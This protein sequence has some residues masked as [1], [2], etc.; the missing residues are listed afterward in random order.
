VKILHILKKPNDQLA[1]DLIENQKQDPEIDVS[2]L[3]IHDA[4]YMKPDKMENLF[5]CRDDMEARC[6]DSNGTPVTYEEI[7]ELLLG[8]DSVVSW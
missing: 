4:V 8:S 3:L 1:L 6:V 7:V 2:L 5:V